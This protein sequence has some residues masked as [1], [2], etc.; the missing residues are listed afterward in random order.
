MYI[1]GISAFYHDAAAAL[2][3][4]GEIVAAA[5]EER[6][7]RKK[8]DPSMPYHAM[9]YCLEEGQITSE[10]LSAIVYY[11]NPILTLDR[12]AKNIQYAGKDARDLVVLSYESF[13]R[14]KIWLH[15]HIKNALGGA[16]IE[17]KVYVTEHHVS[18][19]S[20]AFFPSPFDRAVIMTID[21]VGEWATTTIGYGNGNKIELYKEIDYPHSLGLLYSAFTYFCGFRVNYGDYKLMGLAPYGKPIYYKL[22]KEE[23][24]DIKTDGSYCLNLEYF[25]FQYGRCMTNEKF[26]NLFG[27][28]RRLPE[29]KITRREMDMASSIQKVIEEGII[30]MAQNAKRLFG[31]ETD[32]LVMAGGVALN[33][34]ANGAL[35][36]EKIF[37]NIWVQPAA[38]DAGGALGA[39]LYYYY[40]FCNNK[41]FADEVHDMMKGSYLGPSFSDEYIKSYLD[42]HGYQYKEYEDLEAFYVEI[43]RLIDDRKV[44]GLFEGKM[45]FGPRALGNRSII[46]DARSDEMQSR[47]NLKIKFRE[48]FRPFAPSVLE[49]DAE[50]YFK[51]KSKSPYMLFCAYVQDNLRKEFQLDRCSK[52]SEDDLLEVINKKRSDIPAVTHVD[53]S[54]RVQTVSEEDNPMYYR[55][56]KALRE[57]TGCSVVI[58]TSFNVRGEPVVCTP[59]DAYLCFMRTDMDVLVLG[60][61]ILVKDRQPKLQQQDDWRDRYELD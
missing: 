13:F 43:A 33:C 37:K 38:G 10:Q 57:K 21:G 46:G 5:Q 45:E 48:S 41:R 51:I 17:D 1:L 27:G 42:Q 32:N 60:H 9:K 29:S 49:E 55:I 12:F 30:L 61:M 56:L 20:S 19:A 26:A 16:D 23:L 54:A 35:Q 36:R 28:E 31:E 47:L 34:V 58:N 25:D 18:H 52:E 15:R 4:D 2:V 50:K 7:T 59:E 24:I 11:D 40:Q 39:A 22:I 3:K 8:H 14:D 53:Y 6:F 44:I